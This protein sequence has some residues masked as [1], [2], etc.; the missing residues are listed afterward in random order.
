MRRF[1]NRIFGLDCERSIWVEKEDLGKKKIIE[2][3]NKRYRVKIPQKINKKVT[4]RLQGLGQTKGTKTGD[5]FLHVWLNKGNDI[6]KSLWLS[7]T[8]ARN[9]AKKL[10]SVEE[11]KLRLFVPEKCYNGL[12]VCLRDL[13]KK[14]SFQW[15]APFLRRK[16]GDLFVKLCVYPDKITPKYGSFEELYID[17]MALEGWV[18]RKIDEIIQKIGKPSFSVNPIQAD[19]IADLYNE[20]G[21]RKIFYKLI[22]HLNLKHLNIELRKSDSISSPGN[23]RETIKSKNGVTVSRNYTIKINENFLDNPFSIA[24]IIAHELCHIIYSER[25]EDKVESTTHSN[26]NNQNT[27]EEERTVDL[28]VFMFKIGEFQLRFARDKRLT[29]GYFS[30]DIFERVQVIVSRKFSSLGI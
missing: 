23:C 15:R 11:K 27:L 1:W 14:L 19:T 4:L 26:K 13:G 22:D 29:L 10:L 5:F 28:L 16:R 2:H 24:A 17:D 21:W 25:I 8:S 7:E 30:Q 6:R 12:V 3:N 20:S 18:Y 9:G